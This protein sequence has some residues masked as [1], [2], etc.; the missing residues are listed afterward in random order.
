MFLWTICCILS[1]TQQKIIWKKAKTWYPAWFQ[2]HP[3]SVWNFEYKETH[4]QL[5]WSHKALSLNRQEVGLMHFYNFVKGTSRWHPPAEIKPCTV[6]YLHLF[7]I[8]LLQMIQS[9]YKY[10]FSSEQLHFTLSMTYWSNASTKWRSFCST[11]KW[12]LQLIAVVLPSCEGRIT[13]ISEN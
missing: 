9:P 10:S 12:R 13:C 5:I 1:E 11:N 6:E 3:K 4:Y 2:M 8:S 7:G